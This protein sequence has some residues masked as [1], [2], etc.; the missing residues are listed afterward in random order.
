MIEPIVQESLADVV[1]QKLYEYLKEKK[2]QPGDEF[3]HEE[4]LAERFAI[5][6]PVVREALSRLRMMG[7]VESRKRRG[8]VVGAPNIFET[9]SKL[10]A[11]EFLNDDQQYDFYNFRLVI[12]LGLA[13]LLARNITQE[14]IDE[15]EQV[16]RR[17]ESDTSDFKRYMECDSR[18]HSLLYKATKNKVLE[19]FQSLLVHF[20]ANTDARKSVAKKDFS[21]RF[22]NP[23]RVTHRTLL[24]AIKLRDP[25]KINRAMRQHLAFYL[26]P[27][28]EGK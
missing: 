8:M 14:E 10:I 17:E 2:L 25:E 19:A 15:L 16:V 26:T 1:E 7:F 12:E 5:S 20:F 21:T 27:W 23:K 6:R 22:E 13:D 18:F 4:E 24:E 3:P 28:D 11:P 9:L